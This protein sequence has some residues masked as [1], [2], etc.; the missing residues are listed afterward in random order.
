LVNNFLPLASF[1]QSSHTKGKDPFLQNDID[2]NKTDLHRFK[3][4]SCT[5]LIDEQ[6][7]QSNQLQFVDTAS[8]HRGDKLKRCFDRAILIIL[9][10]LWYLLFDDQI[11][12]HS[13]YLVH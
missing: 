10:S 1:I 13:T 9:L 8:R 6:S 4:S 3:P 12:C 2:R 11:V 5:V 7:N